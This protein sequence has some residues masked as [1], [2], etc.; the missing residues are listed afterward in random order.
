MGVSVGVGGWVWVLGWGCGW[1]CG[2]VRA[3]AWVCGCG[4]GVRG[5]ARGGAWG[6]G[7]AHV[8]GWEKGVHIRIMHRLR[9]STPNSYLATAHAMRG[10]QQ[11]HGR[12]RLRSRQ[13]AWPFGRTGPALSSGDPTCAGSCAASCRDVWGGLRH[14]DEGGPGGGGRGGGGGH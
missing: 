13:S 3:C 14:R 5:R 1:G 2:S 6:G 11:S 9:G 8:G 7:D 12:H 4:C 10:G